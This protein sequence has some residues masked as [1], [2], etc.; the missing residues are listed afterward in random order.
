MSVSCLTAL[1]VSPSPQVFSRGKRFFS[2][3]TTSWPASASQ[4]AAAAPAGPPPTTSTSWRSSVTGP[5]C[6]S[7]RRRRRRL[8]PC[9]VGLLVLVDELVLGGVVDRLLAE[10]L[11][12][13]VGLVRCARERLADVAGHRR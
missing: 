12:D 6:R 8:H 2:T 5:V 10:L 3:T 1:G 9:R 4:N 13:D 7:A 11:G